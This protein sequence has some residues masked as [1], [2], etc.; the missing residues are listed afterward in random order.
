MDI[1]NLEKKK[2]RKSEQG[3]GN[4][5][6]IIQQ[7]RRVFW[8]FWGEKDREKRQKEYVRNNG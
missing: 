7:T 6:N 8:K 1:T 4:L 3:Q 2:L 5:W